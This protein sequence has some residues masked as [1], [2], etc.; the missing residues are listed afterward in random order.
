MA[1]DQIN[2]STLGEAQVT[3]S[4]VSINNIPIEITEPVPSAVGIGRPT[5]LTP[6]TLN[7][8]EEAFS[9]GATDKEACFVSGISHQTLYNYQKENPD[10]IDR[11]EALKDMPK[12]QARAN[13]AKA[14]KSRSVPVSQWYAER[15]MKDEFSPKQ[16]IE[17]NI[18]GP[19]LIR[20]D[21]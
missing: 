17:A 13:I 1:E 8:L 20:L 7:K 10:F 16:E 5:V 21:E 3:P 12:Y 9:Y 19:N 4:I 18:T 14:I 15:K 2:P 6:E 11:K